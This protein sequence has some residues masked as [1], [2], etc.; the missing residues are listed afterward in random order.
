MKPALPA[1]AFLYFYRLGLGLYIALSDFTSSE[2]RDALS[3]LLPTVTILASLLPLLLLIYTPF[4]PLQDSIARGNPIS[5]AAAMRRVLELTWNLVLSGIAQVVILFVPF[6]VLLVLPWLFAAATTDPSRL[7]GVMFLIILATF[8]PIGVCF[9]L[10]FAT[11]ALVLDEEG[12]LQSIATSVRLV[13]TNF[14]GLAGRILALVF[15]SI[16]VYFFAAVPAGILSTVERVS[17]LPSIP[18]KIAG[19]VWSSAV[20]T[21]FFPFWVA[22]LLLLYRALAPAPGDARPGAPVPLDEEQRPPVRAPFE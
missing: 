16:V 7:V 17:G 4:L 18:L 1:L 12:P 13:R 9:L 20:G 15:L 2:G 8:W 14:W 11:P 3:M 21:L 22:A 5:F 19:T 10:M 6:L